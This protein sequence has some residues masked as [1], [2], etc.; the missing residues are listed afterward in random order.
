MDFGEFLRRDPFRDLSECDIP[1]KE[2]RCHGCGFLAKYASD[3]DWVGPQYFEVNE[4]DREYGVGGTHA[5]IA[6]VSHTIQTDLLCFRRVAPLGAEIGALM[7]THPDRT[8][9]AATVAV[10]E[11]ERGC[12]EWL[13]YTPEFSPREHLEKLERAQIEN[14]RR[15]FER[16]MDRERKDFDLGLSR[17]S[18]NAIEK[19]SRTDRH[20]TWALL[21]LACLAL[22]NLV[23]P[24]GIPWIADHA[25]GHR[26]SVPVVST[27]P[28]PLPTPR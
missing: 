9:E 13:P 3:P 28:T 12:S 26:E 24:A 7:A 14:N 23:Y 17:N 27:S 20:L 6:G 1:P 2:G 5:P 8:V 10:I 16:G 22:T 25:P 19:S 18:Q 21:V 15:E 4:H 11:R